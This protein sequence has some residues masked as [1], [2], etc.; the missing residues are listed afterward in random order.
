V[1]DLGLRLGNIEGL[2]DEA[3]F[4]L[5]TRGARRANLERNG[6]TVE[7]IDFLLDRRVE[8][9]AMTSGQLVA[10]LERKLQQHGIKKVIPNADTLADTYCLLA[11]SRA[12]EPVVKRELAKFNEMA[13]QVPADLEGKVRE[14]LAKHPEVRWDEAVAAI[15]AEVAE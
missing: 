9:N 7:E 2:A 13:V 12:A 4:D 15:P 10:F 3:V 5:G 11:H 14:H 6:A 1:I 8:L